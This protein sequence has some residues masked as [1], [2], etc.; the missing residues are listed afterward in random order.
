MILLGNDYLGWIETAVASTYVALLGQG[1]LNETRSQSEIDTGDKTSGAY[2]TGAFGN[3]V[4]KQDLDLK[5]NLPDAGYTRLET[6]VNARQSFMWEV[7]KNGLAGVEADAIFKAL[8]FGSI[9]SRSFNKDGT[10]DAKISLR[11]AA[12]PTI[13]A[14]A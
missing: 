7:R 1:T 6:K 12:A 14:I 13:D 10:V 5:I 9:T 8:V 11:I 3:I 2:G 4:V